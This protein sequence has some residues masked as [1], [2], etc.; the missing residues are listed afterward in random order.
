MQED[1]NSFF[2]SVESTYC[3]DFSTRD[4]VIKKRYQSMT[5]LKMTKLAT[6]QPC[7]DN[8]L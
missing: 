2:L 8:Y 5:L 4:D 7:I 3:E 1:F 6:K